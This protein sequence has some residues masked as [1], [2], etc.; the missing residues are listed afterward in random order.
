[1]RDGKGDLAAGNLTVTAERQKS[2]DF[3]ADLKGITE[4]VVAA[5]SRTCTVTTSRQDRARAPLVEL[6]RQPDPPQ[7]ALSRRA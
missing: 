3:A 5:A 2:V 1:L 7:Q 6:L 4:I